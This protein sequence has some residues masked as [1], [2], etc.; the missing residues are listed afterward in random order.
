MEER[1]RRREKRDWRFVR[2]EKTSFPKTESPFLKKLLK[3][4]NEEKQ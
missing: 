3:M 2:L 1:V 4:K